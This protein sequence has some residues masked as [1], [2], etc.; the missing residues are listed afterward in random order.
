MGW[1]QGISIGW[2]NATY[3]SGTP[4]PTTES[5]YLW[6]CS[7]QENQTSIPYPI[8]TFSNNGNRILIGNG[9]YGYVINAITPVDGEQ[10]ESLPIGYVANRCNDS[11][12]S[13]SSYI[14]QVDKGD[15]NANLTVLVYDLPWVSNNN[16]ASITFSYNITMESDEGAP[17]QNYQGQIVFEVTS[18]NVP[19]QSVT[20]LKSEFLFNLPSG[21]N[22]YIADQQFTLEG[23]TIENCINS[24]YTFLSFPNQ[25]LTNYGNVWTFE[26]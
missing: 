2:P 9:G 4:V 7:V 21:D 13:L 10:I 26:G 6:S 1:G 15:W 24:Y 22:Y 19:I 8:G 5:Y 3:Q 25:F 18:Y 16:A 14:E 12:I 17:P 23:I 11:G 20:Q